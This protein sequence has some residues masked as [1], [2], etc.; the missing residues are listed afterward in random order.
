MGSGRAS[1]RGAGPYLARA[2][3][4]APPSPHPAEAWSRARGG[5][6]GGTSS[7]FP[8]GLQQTRGSRAPSGR[9]PAPSR[10]L[11]QLGSAPPAPPSREYS[12]REALERPSPGLLPPGL[13]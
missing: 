2:E 10:P 1:P 9:R 7:R 12:A 13:R 6:G 5:G 3:A 11:P 8:P 4:P